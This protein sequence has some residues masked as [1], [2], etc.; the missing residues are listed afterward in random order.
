MKKNSYY[1][2]F[3]ALVLFIGGLSGCYHSSGSGNE[4]NVVEPETLKELPQEKTLTFFAPVESKSSGA[5]SYRKLIDKYNKS[6]DVHVVFEGIA[7]ADGYNEYLE[8]RLRTGKGDDIFVVNEDSVKTFAQEGYFY[9]L[10]SLK[11]FEKMNKSARDEAVIGD[12]VYCIPM[13]MTAYALFVNKDVLEQYEL[14]PPENLEEF[15]ACC[16]K[17]KELGGT[18]L[19]LSRWHATAVP[20]IANG[21]YKL[22]DDPDFQE[23]LERLNSGEEQIGGYMLEGFQ[24][25]QDMVEKGWYGDGVSGTDADGLRAGER[26]I[27][28]FASGETAFYFGPLEYIPAVDEANPQLDYHVQGIP[29][30]E[31]TAL[32][33]TAVSRLCVNPDSESLEDAMEFVAYLS[34]EYYKENM[35][36]RDIILPV[37][38]N[39][40][41]ILGD[42]RMRPA[43]ETYLSGIRIPAEDM[44]LRFGSWDVVRELCIEMFDGMTA[45]EAAEKYN[46]IQLEQIAGYEK[47]VST[48]EK[49]K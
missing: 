5:V 3:G 29:V 34:E 13:N 2:F 40:E 19:S 44:Q 23:Q 48:F 20:T 36:K 35:E 30:P 15:N 1:F 16:T 32:L 17:I 41:F 47:Q 18:P 24:I 25:F 27:P 21:L 8:E 11:A 10:S 46:Q 31:G 38:E 28:D 7:T 26:D 39:A 6:H 37:Y 4:V 22:Y 12:T 49:K 43:Y 14:Q 42:E 45:A 9:D 33:T